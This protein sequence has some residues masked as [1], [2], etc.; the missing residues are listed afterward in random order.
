MER[1][2]TGFNQLDENVTIK[3]GELVVIASRPAI[4]KTSFV[5]NVVKNTLD[6][7]KILF[8]SMQLKEHKAV[9][10]LIDYAKNNGKQIYL[11]QSILEIDDIFLKVAELKIKQGLDLVVIDNF[12]DFISCSHYSENA[13]VL[14]LKQMALKLGVCV[15][16][17]SGMARG[18]Y[19]YATYSDILHKTFLKKS[20]KIFVIYRP[21]LIYS[22]EDCEIECIK[23][24]VAVV[25][26]EKDVSSS[27]YGEASLKF[28]N[29]NL[30]FT[31]I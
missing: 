15:L 14:K 9:S 5:C 26:L 23:K 11:E 27:W 24:G 25:S 13:L 19:F 28:D 21:D 6:K 1:I 18:E 22:E 7:Q 29:T 8:F 2:Y 12:G 3:T 20:D 16:I 17:T 30:T 4:G 10:N 31:E